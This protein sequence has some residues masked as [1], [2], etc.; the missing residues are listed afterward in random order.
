MAYT[1]KDWTDRHKTRVDTTALVTHLTREAT[2]D[3][4]N[5]SAV[6]VL[7]KILNERCIK[8]STTSSGYIVGSRRAVCFQEA[9]LLGL[10]QNV[11]YEKQHA[12]GDALPR[13]RGVG[14]SFPKPYAFS[15]G[16]RPV[17]YEKTEDAKSILPPDEHWRIVN[18]D[19]SDTKSFVDWTHEREWRAPGDF[20][21]EL[22]QAAVL[23]G[24]S[25]DYRQFVEIAE[26]ELLRSIWFV[27]T[28]TQA[29]V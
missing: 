21:F 9:P 29:N 7:L 5:L 18:F 13:Y 20:T 8:G 25:A 23:L 16:A 22:K 2:V 28:L 12:P 27:T 11:R 10:A 26:P 6:E 17:F 14:I 1:M 24:T 4:K 19:L 3:G 15:K